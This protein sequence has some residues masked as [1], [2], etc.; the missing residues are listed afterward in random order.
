MI[1]N[2]GRLAICEA[3]SLLREQHFHKEVWQSFRTLQDKGLIKKLADRNPG[4]GRLIGKGT[5][6][7]YY[8][9]TKKG[10]IALIKE[11]L[12]PKEF[13]SGLVP[14]SSEMKHSGRSD[15]TEGLYELYLQK[16]LKYSSGFD[17]NIILLLDHFNTMC[18]EWITKNTD[19]GSITLDQ[20]VLE[21]LALTGG[22]DGMAIEEIC[23]KS[24]EESG[25]IIRVLRQYTPTQSYQSSFLA[26]EDVYLDNSV[27]KRELVDTVLRNIITIQTING[28]KKYSLSL[29]G[30]MLVLTLIRYHDMKRLNLYLL[31]SYPIHEAFD[32][33]ALNYKNKLP[34]IFGHWN[35]LKEILQVISVY[36][37]DVILDR[38]A[39][40]KSILTPVNLK[41]NREF[42][43]ANL[44]VTMYNRKQMMDLYDAGISVLSISNLNRDSQESNDYW[45]NP[46]TNLIYKKLIEI[47]FLLG[48]H[49]NTGDLLEQSAG[50]RDNSSPVYN[51]EM[52]STTR[53]LER[54]FAYEITFLYYLNLNSDVYVPVLLPQNDYLSMFAGDLLSKITQ[55]K[56]P[57]GHGHEHLMSSQIMKILPKSPRDRLVT[58]LKQKKQVKDW[59][60]NCLMNS[61]KFRN[62]ADVTMSSFYS[63]IAE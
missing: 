6:R 24:G 25:E 23:V 13:W 4:P 12:E 58:I 1:A 7:N 16:Y 52:F 45:T 28:V 34:L 41:G 26:E 19:H 32:I 57:S 39:R 36:N 3:E 31:R 61:I 49:P 30:I 50:H 43:E 53:I 10:M 2:K 35:T 29:F 37:F 33:L 15:M 27:L 21:I 40:S 5:P 48:Y 18:K 55:D 47:G 17:Y 62:A 51:E 8:S 44:G 9:I 46:K 54:S 63:E 20:K 22:P 42:Y 56:F 38:E 59:F 11:G 14:Y 60:S